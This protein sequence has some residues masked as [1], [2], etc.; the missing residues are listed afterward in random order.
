[1]NKKGGK[2]IFTYSVNVCSFHSIAFLFRANAHLLH[3]NKELR[4][5]VCFSL[6][7]MC[8]HNNMLCLVRY[9]LLYLSFM[10]FFTFSLSGQPHQICETRYT[11]RSRNQT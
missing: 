7:S 11:N 3:L 10:P 8:M 5:L 6:G 9:G 4:D 2:I 1:M